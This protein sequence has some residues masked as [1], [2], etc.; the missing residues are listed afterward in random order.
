MRD[1]EIISSGGGITVTFVSS[2]GILHSQVA[3]V[4]FRYS[5][6]VLVASTVLH[7]N[8]APGQGE[9]GVLLLPSTFLFYIRKVLRQNEHKNTK[10]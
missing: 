4:A 9:V 2:C 8:Q 10:T 1:E 3:V 6:L 7:G 5:V